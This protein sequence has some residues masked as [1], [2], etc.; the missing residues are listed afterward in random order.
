[1]RIRV[2]SVLAA[3][4]LVL[5]GAAA[6]AQQDPRTPMAIPV[7]VVSYFPIDGD[8]IDRKVT[9]DWGDS[10][11]ATKAKCERLTKETIAALE[12]G[13]RFRGY[14]DA[15]AKPSLKYTVAG[16]FE[17]KKPLP[18][19]SL[20]PGEKVPMTDYNAIMRE[21]GIQKWVE[22]RGVKEVWIWGYHGGVLNLWESNMSGPFGDTSNSSRDPNDLPKLKHT[23]TVYHY[24]YQRGLG[25]AVED[26]MHQ[27]EALLNKVDG[28]DT[29]PPEKWPD[30]LFWGKFVGSDVSHKIVTTP[31]HCGWTH[32]APNSEKDYDW[33]NKRYVET[34]IEDWRPDGGG[35]TQRM[36]CDRWGGDNVRWK[37]YWLQAIPGAN[38][39][40][41]F[42]GR[43]LR[44]WWVFVADWDRAQREKWAL[45]VGK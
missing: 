38:S 9:G 6:S 21:I 1:M 42:K 17:F 26:H 40:L 12:E 15:A 37:V 24:N 2:A 28:R 33:A 45:T 10:Y 41:T 29:T 30:L 27:L 25:E 31:A 20:K 11:A 3:V 5:A 8:N 23:Y 22:E 34:D 14:K 13:S 16:T 18:T 44:N 19:C 36:N 43:P 32:Y 35:Q 39:G 4:G 7:V